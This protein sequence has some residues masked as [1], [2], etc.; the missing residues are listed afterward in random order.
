MNREISDYRCTKYEESFPLVRKKKKEF[1]DFFTQKPPRGPAREKTSMYKYVSKRENSENDKFREI[2][3]NKCV[4]C[5]INIDIVARGSFEVDH[6][7]NQKHT[8]YMGKKEN[9][10]RI[11]NL[12]NSC[13]RCNGGKQG[14]N[15]PLR[16]SYVKL[17][18]PDFEKVHQVF[19]RNSKFEIEISPQYQDDRIVK[20][21]YGCLKLGYEVRRLDYLLLRINSLINTC[22]DSEPKTYLESIFAKILKYRNR[23]FV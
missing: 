13:E 6:F 14:F 8:G 1:E 15:V 2:Y 5:G 16:Y 10:N 4:Y 17:L 12:V 9:I 7:I 23:N 22:I 3:N 19:W 20:D 21:F 11:N 18:H